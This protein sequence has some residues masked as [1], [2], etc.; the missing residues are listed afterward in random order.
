MAID[1]VDLR[2]FYGRP[3]GQVTRRILR[4]K[5]RARWDNVSGMRVLG[6]GYA[7]PFLGQFRDE[8]E[9]VFAF[10][11]APQGVILWPAD[12]PPA[13]ALVEEDMWP[14]PDAAVDRI[15]VV[16][17]LEAASSAADLLRECWRCLAPGGRLL[18]VVPHRRGLWARLDATPFGHGRPFSRMQFA[19]L[20]RDAAFV[21]TLWQDAL[22]FPPI[23]ARLMLRSAVAFERLGGALW[24][25]FAG[26]LV[27]EATKEV[28]A[29]VGPARRRAARIKSA[30]APIPVGVTAPAPH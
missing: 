27:V 20:L 13:A 6:F 26:A 28:R 17:G 5:L 14:L 18:A 16:H 12:G 23:E 29:L 15:L 22:M 10:M 8:A 3:L 4:A 11:P 7:T 21:P 2:S 25:P 19:D 24:S 30:P 9:R 1:A